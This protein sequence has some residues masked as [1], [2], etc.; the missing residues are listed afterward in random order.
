VSK[1]LNIVGGDLEIVGGDLN[2]GLIVRD[3]IIN[4][5]KKEFLC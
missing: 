5:A 4:F 1:D 2:E 3:L